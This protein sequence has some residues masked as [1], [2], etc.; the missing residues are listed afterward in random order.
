MRYMHKQWIGHGKHESHYGTVELSPQPLDLKQ[1]YK[2]LLLLFACKMG[3]GKKKIQKKK[4]VENFLRTFEK[5]DWKMLIWLGK[6]ISVLAFSLVMGL[7]FYQ[8][9]LVPSC[10]F[11]PIYVFFDTEGLPPLYINNGYILQY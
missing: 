2:V 10:G 1:K 6:S 3:K 5:K 8:Y 7:Y 4:K 11:L 9:V